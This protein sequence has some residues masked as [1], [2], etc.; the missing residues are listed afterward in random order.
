MSRFLSDSGFEP[1]TITR[2]RTNDLQSIG[3]RGHI[4]FH[5]NHLEGVARIGRGAASIAFG[6]DSDDVTVNGR[7]SV[8][9][10]PG[11]PSSNEL[12]TRQYVDN[13]DRTPFVGVIT[14]FGAVA[15]E[16]CTQ[17]FIDALANHHTVYFPHSTEAV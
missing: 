12:V 11:S 10:P 5:D 3:G 14:D 16:D 17:A 2:V 6:E 4:A 8:K 7:L 9:N 13:K 15:G 1:T